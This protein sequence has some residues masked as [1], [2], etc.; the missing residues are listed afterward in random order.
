MARRK[1]TQKSQSPT[2]NSSHKNVP[3]RINP[4]L[5]HKQGT[6]SISCDSRVT[7]KDI[8]PDTQIQNRF[9]SLINELDPDDKKSDSDDS[10]I[11]DYLEWE[12]ILDPIPSQSQVVSHGPSRF[13][14]KFKSE[15]R[16]LS[17]TFARSHDQAPPKTEMN[18]DYMYV[19]H[20]T[21]DA[22]SCDQLWD[23]APLRVSSPTPPN[24]NGLVLA[25]VSEVHVVACTPYTS[26]L[27][28][29]VSL[30]PSPHLSLSL[31]LFGDF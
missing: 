28:P 21:S 11:T 10:S 13:S 18:S 17:E 15:E 31:S 23:I 26:S 9:R 6:S 4:R 27:S 5:D 2:T 22:E 3:M 20:V 16:V 30:S 19:S 24:K 14:Q 25:Y 8:T 12:R 29:S 7:E 1:E